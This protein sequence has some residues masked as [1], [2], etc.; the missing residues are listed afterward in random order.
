MPRAR[1]RIAASAGAEAGARAR[2]QANAAEQ[3]AV[4]AL[5]K[6]RLSLEQRTGALE[7]EARPRWHSPVALPHNNGTSQ[8]DSKIII[9]IVIE[10]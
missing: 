6:E 3:R 10:M 5:V 4:E 8:Y 7:R 1:A 2:A 9:I